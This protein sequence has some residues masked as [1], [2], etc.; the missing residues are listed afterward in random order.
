MDPETNL[1][2]NASGY[3]IKYI[4]SKFIFQANYEYFIHTKCEQKLLNICFLIMCFEQF[5]HNE[6]VNTKKEMGHYYCYPPL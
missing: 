5:Y 6:N 2:K 4:Y 1:L 3:W